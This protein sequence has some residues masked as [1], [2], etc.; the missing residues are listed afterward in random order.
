MLSP[1]A[2]RQVS[3]AANLGPLEGA[4]NVGRFGAEGGGPYMVLWLEIQ[5]ER[6]KR[7]AYKSN[8]CPS[9]MACGSMT[10]E[11]LRGRS[12]EEALRLEPEDLILILGGLPEGKEDCAARAITAL[13]N[14][15]TQRSQNP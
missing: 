13:K 6:V 14:A 11:I 8:G 7:A 1:Q 2:A 15:L 12:V 10:C 4:T 9:A 5:D 3:N